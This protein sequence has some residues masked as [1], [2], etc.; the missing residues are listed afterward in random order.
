IIAL[1][2]VSESSPLRHSLGQ[3]DLASTNGIR[4]WLLPITHLNALRRYLKRTAACDFLSSARVATADRIGASLFSGNCM[5]L[6]GATNCIGCAVQYDPRVL[7]GLTDLTTAII[8][9]EAVTNL[10]SLSGLTAELSSAA[11]VVVR[12]NIN[13]AARFQIPKGQG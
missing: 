11:A 12:T 6:N 4:V 8:F 9:S 5:V 1:S 3:P 10:P 7:P 13:L 2:D